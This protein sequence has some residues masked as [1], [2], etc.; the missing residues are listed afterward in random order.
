MDLRKPLSPGRQAIM[1]EVK[2]ERQQIELRKLQ[3][4]EVFGRND[5]Q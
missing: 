3:Q 1:E 5:L 4:E 2:F